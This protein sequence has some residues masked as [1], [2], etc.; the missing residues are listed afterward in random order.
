MKTRSILSVLALIAFVSVASI[1]SFKA[2]DD[3]RS[4]KEALA[5]RKAAWLNLGQTLKGEVDSFSGEAGLVVKD[6][7]TGWEISF[8]KYKSFPSA[9]L[10]K[11][12]IMA[13]CFYT[14]HRGKINL[15]DNISLRPS[16]KT[17]GSGVLKGMANGST[18]SI[19]DIIE[20]MITK[21]D[22]TATNI[23][24][25]MLGFDYLNDSFKNSGLKSTNLVRK[26]MDFK[27][28][29]RGIENYT[30]AE[31]MAFIFERMYRGDL[32]N[33]D[34]SSRCLE[35]LKQQEVNDRIPAK[36]P[37]GTI[38]AHKTGSERDIRHDAGIVFTGKGDYLICILTK[39]KNDGKKAKKFISKV[40]LDVYE[41]YDQL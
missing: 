38:V 11:V 19:E 37:E 41:Y 35:L 22:N 36:L 30:T 8:N 16:Q 1:F 34:I 29:H 20:L 14:A 33:T 17:P 39:S 6:L 3:F 21:S 26:M 15:Y 4:Q 28:R 27:Y 10:V 24:I 5:K 2:Y 23:I 32:F 7:H 13:T 25:D 12:P 9:S 40:A 31:D 18:F